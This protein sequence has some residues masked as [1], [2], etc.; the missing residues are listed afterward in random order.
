MNTA[1]TMSWSERSQRTATGPLE[2]GRSRIRKLVLAACENAGVEAPKVAAR[3]MISAGSNLFTA[4]T[5]TAHAVAENGFGDRIAVAGVT[6]PL[7][8]RPER[9]R[10]VC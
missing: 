2:A 6:H 7:L 4:D 3:D 8:E 5:L 10:V 1:Q 9:L